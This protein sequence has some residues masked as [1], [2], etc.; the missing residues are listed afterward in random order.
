MKMLPVKSN[1]VC[2]SEHYTVRLTCNSH[3][4]EGGHSLY[5][6][7]VVVEDGFVLEDHSRGGWEGDLEPHQPTPPHQFPFSSADVARPQVRGLS[8]VAQSE[9]EQCRV[10]LRAVRVQGEEH[11]LVDE[12]GG[13]R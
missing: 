9:A 11:S 7:S 2:C 10:Q 1:N 3:V 5:V 4:S 13:V 6:Q 12:E 8:S